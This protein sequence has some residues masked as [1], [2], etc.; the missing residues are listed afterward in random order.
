[1]SVP[2]AVAAAIRDESGERAVAVLTS[3]LEDGPVPPGVARAIARFAEG[4]CGWW[5]GDPGDP[6]LVRFFKAVEQA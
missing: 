1:M 3:V 5:D 4:L 2:A 6:A